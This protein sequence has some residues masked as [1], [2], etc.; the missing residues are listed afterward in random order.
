MQ[1]AVRNDAATE[2]LTRAVAAM[3]IT[4]KEKSIHDELATGRYAN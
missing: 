3:P 4:E 2:Y 1:V